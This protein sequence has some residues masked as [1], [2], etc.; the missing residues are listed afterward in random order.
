M[1]LEGGMVLTVSVFLLVKGSLKEVEKRLK[2]EGFSES[3]S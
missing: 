1:R 2:K 3:F